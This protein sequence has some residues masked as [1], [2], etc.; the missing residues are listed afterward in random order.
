MASSDLLASVPG[1]CLRE[2][3]LTTIGSAGGRTR[4]GKGGQRKMGS[5]QRELRGGTPVGLGPMPTHCRAGRAKRILMT[6]TA[7]PYPVAFRARADPDWTGWNLNPTRILGPGPTSIRCRIGRA[8]G[9]AVPPSLGLQGEQPL[10]F[11][12]PCS[13]LDVDAAGGWVSKNQARNL[14]HF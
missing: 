6:E 9:L 13:R 14:R 7:A 10:M 8:Q 4:T 1:A 2:T 11:Q 3:A 5:P 12:T